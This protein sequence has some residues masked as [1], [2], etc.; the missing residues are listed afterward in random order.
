MVVFN[1]SCWINVETSTLWA[2]I[3]PISVII[4]FNSGVLIIA[5]YKVLSLQNR[6][7]LAEKVLGNFSG[8]KEGYF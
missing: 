2:F 5:L 4:L 3:G 7:S 1:F 6:G 8:Y